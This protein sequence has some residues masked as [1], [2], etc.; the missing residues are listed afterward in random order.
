[1]FKVGNLYMLGSVYVCL[2]VSVHVCVCLCELDTG[3]L[4][5]G[6]NHLKVY[7]CSIS[8]S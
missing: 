5:H 8:H 3:I 4:L 6:W 7:T 2:C 1:M